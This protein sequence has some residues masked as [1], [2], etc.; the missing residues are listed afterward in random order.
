MEKQ[1][2]K[3]TESDLHNIVKESVKKVLNEGIEKLYWQCE[4]EDVNGNTIWKMVYGKTTREAFKNT[5]ETGVRIGMEPKYETLR[6]ATPE[7]VKEFTKMIRKRVK[8]KNK[9]EI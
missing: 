9:G 2:I 7:E 4:F 6:N 1:I 5:Y 8:E 3:L